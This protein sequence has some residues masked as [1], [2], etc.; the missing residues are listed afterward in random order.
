MSETFTL[1]ELVLLV[2]TFVFDE[3]ELS[4]ALVL[5]FIHA[6]GL[7]FTL[8]IFIMLLNLL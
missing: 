4:T 1:S 8:V 7:P 5:G 2:E 6:P 3:L